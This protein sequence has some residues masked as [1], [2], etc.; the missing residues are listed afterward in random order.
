MELS[1]IEQEEE[2]PSAAARPS[3]IA[4]TPLQRRAEAL[5]E[6][7]ELEE[8]TLA[9]L[10]ADDM[11][12]RP[13]AQPVAVTPVPSAACRRRN[14]SPDS[15]RTD[16]GGGGTGSSPPGS[17]IAR[18]ACALREAAALEAQYYAPSANATVGSV[19]TRVGSEGTPSFWQESASEARARERRERM[20]EIELRA[21][22]IDAGAEEIERRSQEFERGIEE[23]ERGD[24]IGAST[25]R[26][27]TARRPLAD[28]QRKAVGG[29]PKTSTPSKLATSVNSQRERVVPS[30]TSSLKEGLVAPF[31]LLAAVPL[32]LGRLVA[33]QQVPPQWAARHGC[34]GR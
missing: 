31:A 30:A 2:P 33:G 8:W 18:R 32:S 9:Q 29:P 4:R 24:S 25:D 6:A 12:L 34:A 21:L 28:A 1:E 26:A 27:R 23:A 16:G 11:E 19:E 3:G 13:R 10:D 15:Q 17:A 5:R 22:E 14:G 20:H 7:K